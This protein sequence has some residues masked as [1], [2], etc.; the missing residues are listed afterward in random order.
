MSRNEII[1]AALNEIASVWPQTV[2]TK[3]I[4]ARVTGALNNLY[5][6]GTLNETLTRMFNEEQRRPDN[7][8]AC[9][10]KHAPTYK[11]EKVEK[12]EP[13][14]NYDSPVAKWF[15]EQFAP[16]V[17]NPFGRPRKDKVGIGHHRMFK[18]DYHK[19]AQAYKDMPTN[20][21]DPHD[22]EHVN[23]WIKAYDSGST[24]EEKVECFRQAIRD[25][26]SNIP[27]MP[28]S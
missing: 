21:A 8:V 7:I 16:A 9:L 10:R 11:T 26:P 24:P 4:K 2:K 28:Q 25:T 18:T 5:N 1:E 27:L 3:A 19:L 20:A 23:R 17:G 12:P 22:L 13:P 15:F 14:V 6:Q